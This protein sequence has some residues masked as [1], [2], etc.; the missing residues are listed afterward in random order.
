MK[1]WHHTHFD[2]EHVRSTLPERWHSLQGY[3]FYN[4]LD[5]ILYNQLHENMENYTAA[6][7][8]EVCSIL[9]VIYNVLHQTLSFVWF[10]GLLPE[11]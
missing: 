7:L 9:Q 2:P 10:E 3:V 1:I 8:D 5:I 4:R 6:Y 11:N